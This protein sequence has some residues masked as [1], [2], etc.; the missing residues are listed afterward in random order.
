MGLIFQ[1]NKNPIY[2]YEKFIV[3][4][5]TKGTCSS[6]YDKNEKSHRLYAIKRLI[7]LAMDLKDPI[8]LKLDYRLE[9]VHL[10]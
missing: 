6:A 2:Y 8:N 3:G 1:K 5:S 7:C 4:V 10:F 9:H